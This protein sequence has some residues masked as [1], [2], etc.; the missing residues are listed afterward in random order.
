MHRS[1]LTSAPH[2]FALVRLLCAAPACTPRPQGRCCYD[3]SDVN[4]RHRL[5]LLTCLHRLHHLGLHT[6]ASRD[7][8]PEE[9]ILSLNMDN[10]LHLDPSA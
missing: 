1:K 2:R 3:D 9:T 5:H 4:H 7:P 8:G 6:H 10:D